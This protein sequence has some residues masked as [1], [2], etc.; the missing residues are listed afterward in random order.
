MVAESDIFWRHFYQ[1]NNDKYNSNLISLPELF[2]DKFFVIPDYQRSYSWDTDQIDDLMKDIEYI[3][4]KDYRHYSGT[5]VLTETDPVKHTYDI[6][7][8][9]QRITS[10]VLLL[11]VIYDIN[12]TKYTHL[13]SKYIAKGSEGDFKTILLPNIEIRDYFKKLILKPT[14]ICQDDLISHKRLANTIADF[15]KWITDQNADLI[16]NAVLNKLGFIVFSTPNTNEV[17]IMFEVINNRG[18]ELSELEKIKNY[19]IYL[20]SLHGFEQLRNTIN[21]NWTKIQGNLSQAD[22]ITIEDENSFLRYCYLVYFEPNKSKSWDVYHELKKVYPPSLKDLAVKIEKYVEF[23]AS[24]SQAY[25]YFFKQ[26]FLITHYNDNGQ[27]NCK[28]NLDRALTYLRC[29]PVNASIMPIY[30]SVMT[31]LSDQPD[32]VIKILQL[33]EIVNFRIYVL[34]EILRRTDSEQGNTFFFA[35][36]FFNSPTW[37]SATETDTY[38]Q[39]NK[40]KV[41]GDIFDWL[42]AELEEFILSKCPIHKL[43][44]ALVLD[45]D[46]DYNFYNWPGI[47]Y[48]LARYEEFLWLAEKQDWKVENI[49]KKRADVPKTPND[50]LSL[51]HL[52]ASKNRVKNFPEDNLQ[53]RRLGNFV[54]LGLSA[55]IQ[56]SADDLPVKVATIVKYN[57][58]GTGS[59]NL[60]QVA[61][62]SAD[63]TQAQQNL[64][65]KYKTDNYYKDLSAHTN[66]IRETKL[67]RFALEKWKLPIEDSTVFNKID[68]FTASP[69]GTS[70]VYHLKQ[71]N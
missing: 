6:I 68:S 28:N 54:L 39:F 51:E 14:L 57:T 11:K 70:K 26:E 63:L 50:Y 36:K 55:N 3:S 40:R 59:F 52:W 47:R 30:L 9:Q 20:S 31:R 18:K 21:T 32:K 60:R 46:E 16:L 25:A 13:F 24:A 35:N 5:I 37:N 33:L 7:D 45:T 67:I 1:M 12:P 69:A 56:Q 2:K 29:H 64:S 42:I 48:F 4:T 65:G 27:Q 61:Q 8:G 53:K 23:I 38:T 66:D 44:E 62:L 19:L 10:L 22:V 41:S 58:T 17:G 34:P 43:I 15:R 71:S 49:L